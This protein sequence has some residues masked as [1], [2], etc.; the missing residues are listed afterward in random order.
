[1][2]YLGTRYFALSDIRFV[3]RKGWIKYSSLF[4][5]SIKVRRQGTETDAYTYHDFC[6]ACDMAI[7]A[8]GVL[9]IASLI[10]IKLHT[11]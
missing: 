10:G 11:S 7:Q 3:S 8:L 9:I 6:V 4:C 5:L 1:M 2:A